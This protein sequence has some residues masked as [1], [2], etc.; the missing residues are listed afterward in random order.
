MSRLLYAGIARLKKYILFRAGIVLMVMLGFFLV[1]YVGVMSGVGLPLCDILFGFLPAM[2]FTSA[3]FSSYFIGQEYHDGTIRNK[4][5]AGYK[6]SEIYFSNLIINITVSVC[7]CG[8]VLLSEMVFGLFLMKG[9]GKSE[10]TISGVLF[11]SFL[12]IVAF[13]S[14][15]TMIAM[16]DQSKSAS[17]I[18]CIILTCALLFVAAYIMINLSEI[19]EYLAA[20]DTGEELAQYR[21]KVSAE[22]YE[23][24]IRMLQ[25]DPLYAK[26]Q[27][28]EI[29]QF[30]YDILPSGQ[31]L[32]YAAMNVKNPGRLPLYSLGIIFV[33]TSFGVLIFQRKNIR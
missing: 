24:Y 29:Y 21:T 15:F 2:G 9:F 18:I 31:S 16:L 30:F 10:K 28:R 25:E 14:I 12:V 20:V 3:V 1:Y 32:Q 26:A 8:F 27:N 22:E 4:L 23:E 5:V 19:D 17:D 6:R 7:Y 11:G 13:C 33:T